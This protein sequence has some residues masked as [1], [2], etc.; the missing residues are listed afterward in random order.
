MIDSEVIERDLEL[1]GSA[2]IGPMLSPS[3]TEEITALWDESNRFRSTIIMKRHGFGS[4][5]YK[6]F[7]YLLPQPIADLR[8][9]LYETL[10]PIAQRWATRLGDDTR[11]PPTL[12]EYTAM[13]AAVGQTKPTP[14]L[15]SY[16]AGDY[17]CLHQDLYGEI[18]FPLQVVVMLSP[19]ANYVGGSL[20]LVEQRPR[21]QSRGDSL[22]IEQGHA[23]V[24]PNR[25]RPVRGTKGDYRVNV[26]HGVSTVQAGNRMTLGIIFHDAA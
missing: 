18:A 12:A 5:E 26:R 24:F 7:N 6:Y 1:N 16:G 4:G 9:T 8:A 2:R 13:C 10:C 11:Y 14:L 19:S 20:L 22:T 23:V 17:N 21:M 15:L 3:Q 25:Y